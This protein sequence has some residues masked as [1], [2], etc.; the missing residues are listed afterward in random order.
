MGYTIQ[1]IGVSMVRIIAYAVKTGAITLEQMALLLS[2]RA[3]RLFGMYPQKGVLRVGSDAD[4]V[5]FDPNDRATC[6]ACDRS[7]HRA[8]HVVLYRRGLHAHA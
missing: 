4:I 7:D 1:D 6:A 8:D 2:E 5:I 3:A